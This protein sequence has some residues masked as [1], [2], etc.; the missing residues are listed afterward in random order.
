MQ[1][2]GRPQTIRMVVQ[3]PDG[4]ERQQEVEMPTAETDASDDTSSGALVAQEIPHGT[5]EMMANLAEHASEGEVVTGLDP[6]EGAGQQVLLNSGNT[7]QTV[8]I[9]P[10]DSNS[11]EVSYVLIVSQPDD[12]KG[13]KGDEV[14]V[15]M[16]VYD[17]NE[18]EQQGGHIS[19]EGQSVHGNSGMSIVTGSGGGT[20]TKSP[21]VVKISTKKS[22]SVTQAHMCNYCNYTSPKRYLLSRHMKS[23]SEERPHKCSVCERGFKTLAS[24]QNHVNTHTGTRP[25]QCKECESAFTT[26]GLYLKK[27]ECSYTCGFSL[28]DNEFSSSL[29]HLV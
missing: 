17:F 16:S 21:R 23:H 13:S 15:D 1:V 25:H 18:G 11:G 5:L 4:T 24:L 12:D 20:T 26:S 8:T 2:G 27:L 10:S 6:D 29:M 28:L 22:Q 19:G 3:Q 9:V 14:D 7:Y